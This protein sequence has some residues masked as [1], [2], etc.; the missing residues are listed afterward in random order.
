MKIVKK[1]LLTL[2]VMAMMFV[3]IGCAGGA[4]SST[5]DELDAA[6]RD[7]SS[8]LNSAI[9]AGN[10]IV[11]LNI[12]SDSS[13]LSDYIIDEL[14]AN[15]VN[16]K[17]FSVVDRNQ[18]DAI[19]AEQ[20]FQSSGEVADDQALEIGK[21]FGA[22]TIVSGAIGALGSGYRIRVRALNVE[23][24]VV[25][26]QFNRNITTSPLVADI[27]AS[28]TGAPAATTATAAASGARPAATGSASIT[29]VNNTGKIIEG[30]GYW[31]TGVTNSADAVDFNLKGNIKNNESATVTVTRYDAT[32]T[33]SVG[34]VDT[35]DNVYRY[36]NLSFAPKMTITVTS[37]NLSKPMASTV[38]GA[39][40]TIPAQS[41]AP[42]T[43]VAPPA[44]QTYKIGDT[45]PAGGLIFYD[46]K[47]NS[48]GWR[49][50]EA[51]PEEAEFEVP[52]TIRST[53]VD[54]LQETIGSG[55][56]NTQLIVEKFRQTSGEW[57][58]AAQKCDDLEFNGFG[59][60][61]LPSKAELDQMYGNLKRRNLG[62]F[63]NESYWSS[64]T[65]G[66]SPYQQSFGTGE[67]RD[68]W[69]KTDR[70]HVRPIR[71]VPGN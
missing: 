24:A 62:D 36:E 5:I 22:Q 4:K 9:P 65:N 56:R 8:Y 51:A 11:I 57:D 33:Y 67:I 45:G 40:S 13:A 53:Q 61:F 58:T 69:W 28:D 1:S 68:A 31:Q 47:N 7:T 17:I 10:K 54:G 25:Q 12:Q 34:L 55:R 18:L 35:E 30:A 21:F 71:Q 29:I 63:K 32:K 42:S 16:D 44:P 50:L 37:A 23:T 43:P 27:K 48:G 49:Y 38:Q 20:N 26:G 14:I 3:A 46:K 64:S 2:T 6:I 66:S 60:W 52:W 70:R 59:D 19:R 15:A 39:T 41:S